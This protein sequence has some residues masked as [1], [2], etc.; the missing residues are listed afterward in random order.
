MTLITFNESTKVERA[1]KSNA[2]MADEI[3]VVD[4][5]STDKT[6]EICRK[7]TEQFLKRDWPGYR[8]QKNFALNQATH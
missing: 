6:E 7:Y 4:S 8:D 2:P 3:V 1:L 5:F